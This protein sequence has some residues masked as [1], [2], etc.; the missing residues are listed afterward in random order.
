MFFFPNQNFKAQNF[1]SLDIF[2]HVNLS[3]F[4]SCYAS[5]NYVLILMVWTLSI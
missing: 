3:I 1:C 5:V 4:F 2:K